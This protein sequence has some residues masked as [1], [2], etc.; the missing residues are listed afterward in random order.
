MEQ[1]IEKIKGNF[2]FMIVR[3]SE[4]FTLQ[5]TEDDIMELYEKD[6]VELYKEEDLPLE[7]ISTYSDDNFVVGGEYYDCYKGMLVGYFEGK[8]I[9]MTIIIVHVDQKSYYK[10]DPF[11]LKELVN[12]IQED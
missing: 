10:G 2:Y 1:E 12:E 7:D 8:N 4:K 9:A 5:E 3:D 6:E 11:N